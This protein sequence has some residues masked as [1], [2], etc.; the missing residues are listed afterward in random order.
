MVLFARI[1]GTG[2]LAIEIIM[3]PTA[4]ADVTHLSPQENAAFN[5]FAL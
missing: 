1:H 3:Q 5:V 4:V 2:S